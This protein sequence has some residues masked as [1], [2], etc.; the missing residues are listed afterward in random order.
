[1]VSMPYKIVL[2]LGKAKL[3][4]SRKLYGYLLP[5]ILLLYKLC[6]LLFYRLRSRAAV[7][8]SCEQILSK[9]LKLEV[10]SFCM[11]LNALSQ[12]LLILL[13]DTLS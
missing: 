11:V 8:F 7:G 3:L 10:L 9:S 1:M 2:A 4:F 6:Y 12:I 13:F 5:H